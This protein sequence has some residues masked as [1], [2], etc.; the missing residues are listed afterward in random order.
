M[1]LYNQTDD[2][3]ASAEPGD[4]PDDHFALPDDIQR[5]ALPS[6]FVAT[7]GRYPQRAQALHEALVEFDVDIFVYSQWLSFTL[8]WDLLVAKALGIPFVIQ[9]HGNFSVLVGYNTPE[10]LELVAAYRLADGIVTLSAADKAFWLNFNDRTWRT[11]NM[12]D[13]ELLNRPAAL[14]NGHDLLW[15]GRIQLDKN[16]LAAL[17]ILHETLKRVP[18]ARLVM[19]GPM[20]P[21]MQD[22]FTQHMTQLGVTDSVVLLGNQTEDEMRDVYQK[23]DLFIMTSHYEGYPMALAESKAAGIPCVM[24]DL[25][26]LTLVQGKSG[27][28]RVK[29]DDTEAF[30]LAVS[31]LLLDDQSRQRL[32][33]QAREHMEQL[34]RFDCGAL[35][36]KVFCHAF[37]GEPAPDSK[38]ADRSE[39][40][41]F[42]DILISVITRQLARKNIAEYNV[43]Q[44]QNNIEQKQMVINDQQAHIDALTQELSD[45]RT[46][47]SLRVGRVLTAP[48]RGIRDFI[49]RRQV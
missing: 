44:L 14:L 23:A 11:Q 26:Y 40:N 47:V 25:P 5:V 7:G 43:A 4:H 32:G 9:T 31:E 27:V 35:W 30:G 1:F 17:D 45:V 15:V 24:Y 20:G 8:P 28:V 46:S 34:S 12:V 49:R 36:E 6:N 3:Q 41:Q 18:D 48:L 16:P 13:A 38:P 2:T 33:E 21:E 19:A 37:S 22:P 39:R 42:W 29:V 10:F